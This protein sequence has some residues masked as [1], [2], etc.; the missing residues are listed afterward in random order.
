MPSTYSPSL[1]IELI[2]TGE[3]DGVW[4][5]TTNN[6]LWPLLEQAITGT[7]SVSVT[8]ADVTLTSLNGAVDEARSAVLNVTG[9]A[10]VSRNIVIPNEP[11][12]YTVFNGADAVVVITTGSGTTYSCAAGTVSFVSSNGSNAVVGITPLSS[13]TPTIT[14]P[15]IIGINE[16]LGVV[17]SPA[18]GTINFD[19]STYNVLYYTSNATAAWV[20]N[21]RGSG[22]A[23]LNSTLGVNQTRSITFQAPLG[24]TP[25]AMSSMTI[26][27][28]AVTVM[29]P[30]GTAPTGNA[31]ALNVYTFAIE[32]TASAT[33]TVLGSM[34]AYS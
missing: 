5:V 9:A 7:T 14:L 25:Y 12:Q 19:A 13:T 4:G 20:L 6:N 31:S 29:W 11:K 24:A 8:A 21:V 15:T 32:K 18:T 28:S 17:A 30:N 22:A 23:T 2:G 27:G 10:G 3:Q 16:P 34:T 26:D 1:R 33:Y